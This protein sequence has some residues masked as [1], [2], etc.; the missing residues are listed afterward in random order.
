MRALVT[1]M[2]VGVVLSASALAPAATTSSTS[3]RVTY[4]DDGANEAASVTWTL[5]CNPPRG[6]L[7]RPAVACDRLSAGGPK[8]FAPLPKAAV[9][10][11]IFGG[12]QRA[13]VVG[14][15]M[16]KRIWATFSRQDGCQIGRW[17]RLAPWLLPPGGAT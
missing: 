12:P 9:C 7:R 10:T 17:N 1:L 6:S 2:A 16:G 4:W 8:L 5:R 13:R 11:Q 15:V 3:V 14:T